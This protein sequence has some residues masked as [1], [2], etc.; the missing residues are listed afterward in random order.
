MSSDVRTALRRRWPRWLFAV[1][2]TLLVVEL[3]LRGAQHVHPGVRALLY[4]PR[5][6]SGYDDVAS[7]EEL[8]DRS[9]I[10]H[11]PYANFCGFILNSRGFLTPEYS[12]RT[13][14]GTYRIV[15]LGDSFTF[16]AGGVPYANQ[17]TTLVQQRLE[18]RMGQKVEVINL[19]V[20]GVGPRFERRVWQ[21]EGRK[22]APDLVV[23]GLYVGNDFSDEIGAQLAGVS[24]SG[25]RE[26]DSLLQ[27]SCL[28]RFA[29]NLWLLRHGALESS[30][31]RAKHLP[32][33]ADAS[34]KRRGG[35][36]VEGYPAVFAASQPAFTEEAYTRMV[37]VA[38]WPYLRSQRAGFERAFDSVAEVL[39]DLASDVKQSGSRLVVVVIPAECQV[40]PAVRDRALAQMKQRLEEFDLDQCQRDLASFFAREGIEFI[41]LL[42]AFRERGASTRLYRLRDSHWDVSG[43]ALA[44]EQI[45]DHLVPPK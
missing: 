28:A 35:Y 36:E 3:G 34:A 7:T 14:E 19:G 13:A 38:M 8:L 5:L 33:Q 10:G 17:W 42:P 30:E 21:L 45:V 41:D 11:S 12:D 25:S 37:G 20:A 22:L 39:R 43:N 44:A 18:P 6:E 40:D 15:A 32:P 31:L 4:I 26:L 29:R 24:V 2:L 9:I 16:K 27:L 23:L 1:V